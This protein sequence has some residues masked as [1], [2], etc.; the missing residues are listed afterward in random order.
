MRKF[1]FKN[2]DNYL[3][4]F[5]DKSGK[6]ITTKHKY[7]ALVSYDKIKAEKMVNHL[8]KTKPGAWE[9]ICINN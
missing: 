9:K 2:G 5:D 6:P 1:I 3:L 7:E 4:G 8:N